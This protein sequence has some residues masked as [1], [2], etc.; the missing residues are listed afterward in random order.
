M[1]INFKGGYFLFFYYQ[2]RITAVSGQ[3]PVSPWTV[4]SV[5]GLPGHCLVC[6]DSLD[7]VQCPWT[8]SSLSTESLGFIHGHPGLC[9]WKLSSSA[10]LTGLKRSMDSLDF[11]AIFVWLRTKPLVSFL[12][13]TLCSCQSWRIN[14]PIHVNTWHWS[15]TSKVYLI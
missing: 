3:S 9:P 7:F 5:Q 13:N 8:K 1:N 4:Q 11:T 12:L 10:G 2:I 14:E 6:L 15:S